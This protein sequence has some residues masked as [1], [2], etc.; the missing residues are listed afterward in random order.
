MEMDL[1]VGGMG[2]MDE[3]K[4]FEFTPIL[5]WSVSRYDTFNFCRRKYYYSY[6]G[7]FDPDV[8]TEQITRLK[9]MTSVA[10]EIGNIVHDVIKVL[11][12]RLQ[13]TEQPINRK[14]FYEYTRRKTQE[15]CDCKVFSEVY[16]KK[17]PSINVEGIYEKVIQS[18]ENLLN[19]ERFQWIL[20]T[21]AGNKQN[22]LI[23]PP[24]FGETR[25]EGLK[26]YCKVDFLFPVG[27]SI[28][29]MDWKTGK[30]NRDKHRK[31]L[32][33]YAT[34]AM[35]HY[36]Q[37]PAQIFPVAA[38][39][40]PTYRE[41]KIEVNEFDLQEFSS[42]VK[43]ETQELRSLCVDVDENIPKSKDSF[44]MTSNQRL[45]GYCSFRELCGIS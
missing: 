20:D 7:K 24:G 42:L 11:L 26:A 4:R 25:I 33:G 8:P 9:S 45:C 5:G 19:S 12:E 2:I 44:P 41:T 36:H 10:L 29:I 14:R 37:D 22:W 38:Y 13:K 40:T 1:T 6:Y 3:L 15:Y 28:F 39:L 35:Y 31:Q 43:E 32:T 16:Y 17:L 21:A 23:E 27:D 18:A 34:F 30:E